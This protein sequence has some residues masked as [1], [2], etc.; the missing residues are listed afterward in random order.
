MTISDLEGIT[1]FVAAQ[2]GHGFVLSALFDEVLLDLVGADKTGES[3][4]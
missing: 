3:R 2:D 1:L 4:R